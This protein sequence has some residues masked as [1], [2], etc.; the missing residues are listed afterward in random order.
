MGFIP[1]LMTILYVLV[2]EVHY[3]KITK[4]TRLW[5]KKFG[6]PNSLLI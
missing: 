3:N 6:M 2:K 4:I 1:E 5:R